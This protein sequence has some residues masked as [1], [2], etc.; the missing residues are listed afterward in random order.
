ML[1]STSKQWHT[2]PLPC[3]A[4]MPIAGRFGYVDDQE[5]PPGGR[6]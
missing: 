6:G 3:A 1:H 5:N 2:V 4:T